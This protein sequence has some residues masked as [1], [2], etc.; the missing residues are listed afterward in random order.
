MIL[1]VNHECGCMVTIIVILI[2]NIPLLPP[3]SV[4]RATDGIIGSVQLCEQQCKNRADELIKR[5]VDVGSCNG[6]GDEHRR[7]REQLFCLL[8]ASLC[9]FVWK[10]WSYRTRA[11]VYVVFFGV[12]GK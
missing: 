9:L 2:M 4:A 3:A 6:S 7:L 5:P 10:R 12:R 11:S 8:S 1:L